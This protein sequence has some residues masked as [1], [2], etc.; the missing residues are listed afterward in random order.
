MNLQTT[1]RSDQQKPMPKR[2]QQCT[3]R[4]VEMFERQ[5]EFYGIE[6]RRGM[7]PLDRT[8]GFEKGEPLPWLEVC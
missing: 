6:D 3:D 5:A 1:F 7:E 2:S 8:L 4:L